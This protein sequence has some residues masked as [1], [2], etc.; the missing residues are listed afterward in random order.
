MPSLDGHFPS[1]QVQFTRKLLFRNSAK[2]EKFVNHPFRYL[3]R[4][5][6]V[7]CS[8]GI[9]YGRICKSVN[10]DTGHVKG[11]VRAS[12]VHQRV[13]TIF[14]CEESLGYW[15]SEVETFSEN[16]RRPVLEFVIERF[17]FGEIA[18]DTLLVLRK[19][20]FAYNNSE[21][22]IQKRLDDGDTQHDAQCS[23]LL[24]DRFVA[25]PSEPAYEPTERLEILPHH[26]IR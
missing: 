1:P 8:Q 4:I 3:Q 2:P 20:L 17:A 18:Q 25:R 12:D 5:C 9:E 22:D 7:T 6:G 10:L 26:T 24:Q 15:R 11:L 14:Q 19:A 16:M 13:A 23:V 21:E